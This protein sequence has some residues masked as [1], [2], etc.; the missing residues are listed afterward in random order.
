MEEKSKKYLENLKYLEEVYRVRT[1]IINF[2]RYFEFEFAENKMLVPKPDWDNRIQP[3]GA[4]GLI[5]WK[6]GLPMS[7]MTPWGEIR[8][9]DIDENAG[10]EKNISEDKV[11]QFMNAMNAMFQL[12]PMAPGQSIR[13]FRCATYSIQNFPWNHEDVVWIEKK[14]MC[15]GD[16]EELLLA[17]YKEGKQL[18]FD[19][20]G[21]ETAV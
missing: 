11:E 8:F 19:L 18:C 14:N 9:V 10:F 6:N 4:I 16:S 7:L 3:N 13:G 15:L 1:F 12:Q 2:M 5:C 20:F 21:R 17:T